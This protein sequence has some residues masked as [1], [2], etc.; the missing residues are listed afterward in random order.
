[1][2]SGESLWPVGKADGTVKASEESNDPGDNLPLPVP[3]APLPVPWLAG[4][5][6]GPP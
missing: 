5:S 1:L 2:K 6:L 4:V 3:N